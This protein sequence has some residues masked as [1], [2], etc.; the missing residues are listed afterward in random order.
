MGRWETAGGDL[1]SPSQA[2][3]SHCTSLAEH[4]FR[5]EIIKNL[6]AAV[7]VRKPQASC[8]S[9]YP[10]PENRWVVERDLQTHKMAI[11][12]SS[13]NIHSPLG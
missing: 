8:S 9:E 10:G 2:P 11:E 4:R 12:K 1:Q 13:K 3:L 7:T 6:E 5:D